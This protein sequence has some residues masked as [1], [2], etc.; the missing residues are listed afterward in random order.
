MTI[1][2]VNGTSLNYESAGQ[3]NPIVFLHG[4]S[5]STQDWA[6]QMKALSPK[7]RVIAVDGRGHGK[8]GAPAREEDYSIP[9]FAEDIYAL[10]KTLGIKKCC[11]GGHS[12]GGFTA[13]QFAVTH[14][15]M[16]AGL[17][18]VDTSSESITRDA[19]YA[20]MRQKLNDLARTQGLAAAFEYDAAH[21]PMRI[22][23]F[24][25]HPEQ[26]EIAL[27]KVLNT[28]VNGYIYTSSAIDKRP[29]VTDQLGKI[30]VPTII[31]WG[32]EDTPFTQPVQV[33]KQKIAGAELVTVKGSGHSPHEEKPEVF[34]QALLKFLDK[35]KW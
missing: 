20:Q 4:F 22:E 2:N 19:G 31:F 18:L 17:V 10:L 8:S 23:R 14:P 33:L 9:V 34:N 16:L 13:L 3:G 7:Y 30:K 25:K 15:E 28:S 27:K 35:V 12:Y 29:V 26:R 5:G 6:N 11:L 1:V 21:N 32:D 24:Q